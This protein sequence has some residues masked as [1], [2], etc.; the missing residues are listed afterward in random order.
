MLTLLICVCIHIFTPYR[1]MYEK[2][3]MSGDIEQTFTVLEGSMHV[4]SVLLFPPFL[5]VA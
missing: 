4:L 1:Y 2:L 3:I 5:W